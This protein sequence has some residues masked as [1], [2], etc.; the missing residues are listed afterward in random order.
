MLGLINVKED[1]IENINK[2]LFF[3]K[4]FRIN[5]LFEN[6]F[7]FFLDLDIYSHNNIL[8]LIK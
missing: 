2:D 5:N 1:K 3:N 6:F 7:N 4:V 8:M